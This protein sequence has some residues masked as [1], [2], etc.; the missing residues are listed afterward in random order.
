MRLARIP[1]RAAVA[2][3]ALSALAALSGC[4]I[5]PAQPYGYGGEVVTVA[6]PAPQVEVY[7][8]AP[9]PGWIW[10]SGYW[11]WGGARYAW[12]PGYWSAPHP[13]YRWVPHRWVPHANGWRLDGGRWQRGG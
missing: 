2:A 1:L 13:G 10:I 8:V 12:S 6:P 7:G 9:S 4:V 5:A 3:A 11:R